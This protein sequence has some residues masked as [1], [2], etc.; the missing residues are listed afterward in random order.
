MIPQLTITTWLNIHANF[1]D[2]LTYFVQNQK[3]ANT[4][5]DPIAMAFGT[6]A[7]LSHPLFSRFILFFLHLVIFCN[8]MSIKRSHTISYTWYMYRDTF[9]SMP[10]FPQCSVRRSIF[11]PLKIC[12]SHI[13]SVVALEHYH[14]RL[15]NCLGYINNDLAAR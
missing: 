9:S 8:F 3:C 13:K 12:V 1:L 10:Y 7:P 6:N 5:T 4:R 15:H 11:Y 14:L 2:N